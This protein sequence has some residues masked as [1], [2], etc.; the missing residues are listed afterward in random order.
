MH[1]EDY[2]ASTRL[3]TQPA[4]VWGWAPPNPALLP[5]WYDLGQVPAPL[6]AS[7]VLRD[8][9]KGHHCVILGCQSMCLLSVGC[10]QSFRPF[11][12]YVQSP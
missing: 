9:G 6:G 1:R 11:D 7:Q 12:L 5:Q 3:Q 2:Q 10:L 4:W 8:E